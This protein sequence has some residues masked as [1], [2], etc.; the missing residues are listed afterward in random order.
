MIFDFVVVCPS[1]ES[2]FNRVLYISTNRIGRSTKTICQHI[3][4]VDNYKI[5]VKCTALFGSRELTQLSA[6]TNFDYST[7]VSHRSDLHCN[8][9]Q[10][11]LAL[12]C[13]QY[14]RQQIVCLHCKYKKNTCRLILSILEYSHVFHTFYIFFFS[15]PNFRKKVKNLLMYDPKSSNE[16]QVYPQSCRLGIGLSLVRRMLHRGM[17]IQSFP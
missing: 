3:A 10:F 4:I 16:N 17:K 14:L 12:L 11:I 8:G 13:I 9:Y 2:F 7:I 1:L 6:A 15:I 5:E